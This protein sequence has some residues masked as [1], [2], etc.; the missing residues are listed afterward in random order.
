ML[1]Q[2]S[3]GKLQWGGF[4]DIFAGLKKINVDKYKGVIESFKD[5][6]LS[7]PKFLTEGGKANWDKIAKSI[8]GCNETTLSYF[9]NLED[10][11]GV[12]DQQAASVEG[13]S[14]FLKKE[15]GSA[16]I[17]AAKTALLNAALNAGIILAV[18]LALKGLAWFVDNLT[19]SEEKCKERVDDLMSSYQSALSE[20]NSNA[21]TVEELAD[22]YEKLSKGVNNLGENVSLTT[23]EYA[24]YNKIVNQIADM[25]PNLIQGYTSEGNAILS[26]KGNVEELRNAYKEAQQEAYNMLVV[27]GKDSDGNDIIKNFQN[28]MSNDKFFRWDSSAK[29]YVDIITALYN[30]MSDSE[31]EYKQLYKG[32]TPIGIFR[33][34]IIQKIWNMRKF[35][36]LRRYLRKLVSHQICQN[37]LMRIRKI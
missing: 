30:A 10:G 37:C 22:K 31:E 25:F 7:N 16:E 24:E 1:A 14:E 9:K 28:T 15:G 27:S 19:H 18:S 11:N 12:I 6:N 29:E 35:M 13:L 32:M 33:A 20:A 17:A 21:Q 4:F 34:M 2:I 26:L 23:D 36:I 5:L 3:D 8:K